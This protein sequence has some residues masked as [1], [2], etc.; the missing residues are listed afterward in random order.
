M[1]KR[2]NIV[3]KPTN[4]CNLQCKHCYEGKI[5]KTN[6]TSMNKKTLE[7]IIRMVQD[8]YK[9]VRYSWFGGEPLMINLDFFQQAIEFQQKYNQGNIISNSIQTNGTL[10]NSDIIHFIHEN[11]FNLSISYDGQ[12]NDIL[13]QKTELVE[14][15]MQTLMDNNE[16]FNILCTIHSQ[17]YEHL[18]DIYNFLKKYKCGLKFNP[19]FPS[20][21]ASNNREYLI[22][23][24]L[25]ATR[26]N[27][28][29]QYWLE[30]EQAI[31]VSNF[32]HYIKLFLNLPGRPCI[33]SGCLYKMLEVEP[34]GDIMPCSRYSDKK[35]IISNIN[36]CLSLQEIF[37]NE[38]YKKLVN[39]SITRRIHCKKIC[40]VYKYCLGGCTSAAFNEVGAEKNSSQMCQISQIAFPLILASLK[41]ASKK[42]RG[43]KNPIFS[44]L[45]SNVQK[46]HTDTYK[47]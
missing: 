7:Q 32:I 39:Q 3:I 27:E 44:K 16:N 17:N 33:Y 30:D 47:K 34:N 23:P 12:F 6:H 29:F 9:V 13:R 37:E 26:L 15:N 42:Q 14:K 40:N 38:K 8:N 25:Y 24:K 20:G 31:P 35:Y 46:N 10:L 4:A 36:D 18:I 1:E 5:P 19:I 11:S 2:L 22:N 43:I 45:L 28:F 21:N 41:E